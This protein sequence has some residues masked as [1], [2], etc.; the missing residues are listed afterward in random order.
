MIIIFLILCLL[1]VVLLVHENYVPSDNLSVL[2]VTA[3][4]ELVDTAQTEIL[5]P[6]GMISLWLSPVIPDGWLLCNGQSIADTKYAKLKALLGSDK[7]PDYR[8]VVLAGAGPK[9][10]LGASKGA[11]T[12]TFKP[13]NLPPHKHIFPFDDNKNQIHTLLD[14]T[15]ATNFVGGDWAGLDRGG[16]QMISTK[17]PEHTLTAGGLVNPEYSAV[18]P[19]MLVNYIIKY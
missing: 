4:G 7:V 1:A 12:Q 13:E 14:G 17:W 2:Q 8:G 6:V 3:K 16:Q 11:D 5:P 15:I 9:H 10:A 18:Q 19:S